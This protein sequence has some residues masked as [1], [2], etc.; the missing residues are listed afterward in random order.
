[1]KRDWDIIVV[2]GGP[3]GIFAA[4][5]AVKS[6]ASVLLFERKREMGVPVRCGEAVGK[7][8]FCS[9]MDVD[10]RWISSEVNTFIMVLPNGKEVKLK[11]NIYEGY[12]INRDLF[13]YD[14]A[15]RAAEQGTCIRMRCNVRELLKNAAGEICGVKVEERGEL[16]EYYAKVLIAADGVESRL[17][18]QAE[19]DSV[20]KMKDIEP[21]VQ[22]TVSG[23]DIPEKA[24]YL[25]VG[26]C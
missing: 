7:V 3:A 24:L 13:E 12:I 1:M 8:D 25:Y 18:R 23:V 5:E 16:Q 15:A 9:Y 4:L 14:M 17:A 19:I 22:A 2:G 26:T 10:P 6:G 11:S 21:C 20:L